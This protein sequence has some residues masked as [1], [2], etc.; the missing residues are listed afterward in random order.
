MSP[1]YANERILC[2]TSLAPSSS[3]FVRTLNATR[4]LLRS[5]SFHVNAYFYFFFF[6][7]SQSIIRH[8]IKRLIQ[9]TVNIMIRIVDANGCV[10]T[11]LLCISAF[12]EIHFKIKSVHCHHNTNAIMRNIRSRQD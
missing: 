2:A 6:F 1:C 11:Y 10:L 9:S 8:F 12:I 3:V 4:L 5:F 7:S